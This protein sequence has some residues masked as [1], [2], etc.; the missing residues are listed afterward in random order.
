[1][2]LS[3]FCGAWQPRKLPDQHHIAE[4]AYERALEL[5]PL[6]SDA[7]YNLGNLYRDDRPVDAERCY[8]ASLSLNPD[9]PMCWHN[10]G[11]LLLH[12]LRLSEA[13][14]ALQTSL[15]LDPNVAS[16]WC[17]LSLA[18]FADRRM[19]PAQRSL[20][21]AIALEPSL[22]D[23]TPDQAIASLGAGRQPQCRQY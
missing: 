6:R 20:Q 10:Y 21:R 19:E 13:C 11:I 16:V 9:Q 8:R 5:D 17:N 12:E 18:K 3:S 7:N 14:H 4:A 15:R 22:A 2:P 23:A 1:M